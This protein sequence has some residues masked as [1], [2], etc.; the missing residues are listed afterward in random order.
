MLFVTSFHEDT[1][2]KIIMKNIE[3]KI[4]NTPCDYVKEIFQE[5]NMFLSQRQPKNLLTLPS[6]EIRDYLKEFLNAM[7]KDVKC[8]G[9][10]KH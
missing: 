2:D 10:Q 6:L 5:S 7:I 1:N 3:R 8:A 4:E 9:N